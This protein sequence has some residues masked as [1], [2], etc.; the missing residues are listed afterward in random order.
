MVIGIFIL[1]V[2]GTIAFLRING[3][4]FHYF[5]LNLIQTSKK[6]KLRVWDKSLSE[7]ELK[8]LIK[9]QKVPV[10]KTIPRKAALRASRLEELALIVNTGGVYQ[11][12]EEIK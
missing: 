6:P 12:E 1:A 3:Q 4:P 10:V 9:V 5:L 8:A 7:E 2:T 11:G